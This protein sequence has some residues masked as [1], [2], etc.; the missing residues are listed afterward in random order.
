[1]R[2][3]KHHRE[4]FEPGRILGEIVHHTV[5]VRIKSAQKARAAGRTKRRGAEHISELNPLIR[6]PINVGRFDIRIAGITRSVPADIVAENKENVWARAM[7]RF[8]AASFGRG[9]QRPRK[10]QC[11]NEKLLHKPECW[12]K[13]KLI[14]AGEGLG[15]QIS[16][17]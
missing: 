10:E 1:M 13:E 2:G 15:K 8:R 3:L 9:Q 6:E 17:R 11:A 4:A 16:A 7:L 5:G 12:A 14:Q